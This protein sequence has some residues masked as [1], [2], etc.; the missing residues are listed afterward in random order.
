VRITSKHATP[1]WLIYLLLH[2]FNQTLYAHIEK[3]MVIVI[4]SYNNDRWYKQNL[5]SVFC[6]KYSNYRV[7][8]IND[9]STD[10]TYQLVCDYIDQ[11]GLSDRITIINNQKNVGALANLYNVIHTLSDYAIVVAL[12]GDDTLAHDLVLAKVNTAYADCATWLMYSQFSLQ[13]SGRPGWNT[14]CSKESID[15]A[16]DRG[17]SPT[18]LRTFYAG[19]FKKIKQE[20]LIHEG[21]FFVMAWDAAIM[22]PMMEM[23]RDNH[24]KFVPEILYCYND[25]NPMSDD[26]KN[27]ALQ[28]KLAQII[29]SKKRYVPIEALL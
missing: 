13:S 19:L 4:P 18:H 25:T 6:Q 26:K 17:H 5:D 21:D 10:C 29:K 11:H 27:R 28:I 3:P 20:D 15:N 8:Y 16:I 7:V 1:L 23:A 14:G 9:C 22:F 24:V 2:V 12:D